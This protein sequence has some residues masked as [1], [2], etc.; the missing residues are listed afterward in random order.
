M[1][2]NGYSQI[3]QDLWVLRTLNYKR[4]GYFV[5]IGAMDGIH[6]SNTY[7]ME[8]EFGW[9]GIV[10]EPNPI[11]RSALKKNRTCKK[12]FRAIDRYKKIN[13]EFIVL[14]GYNSGLSCLKEYFDKDYHKDIREKFGKVIRVETTSPNVMLN[15]HKA[16]ANIDYLSID[17]EGNELDILRILDWTKYSIQLITI[18]H[19]KNDIYLQQ[20]NDFLFSKG[21]ALYDKQETY[22]DSWYY[23]K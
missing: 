8:K 19:N 4:N 11:H 2:L 13:R 10:V 9:K 20:I 7:L 18:E 15:F 12:E 21:Y 6:Y 1:E 17:T 16:P 5:E 22:F 14:D 3:G 23:K